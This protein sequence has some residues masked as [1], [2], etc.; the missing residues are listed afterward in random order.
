MI[1]PMNWV[2]EEGDPSHIHL[3]ASETLSNAIA[4][5]LVSFRVSIRATRRPS[6]NQ[7]P[8]P[9]SRGQSSVVW[10]MRLLGVDNWRRESQVLG[11]PGET[12]R[13]TVPGDG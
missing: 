2:T 10:F 5:A 12:S 3:L 8:N 7:S 6:P 13:G 11:Q 9:K 1:F 4:S